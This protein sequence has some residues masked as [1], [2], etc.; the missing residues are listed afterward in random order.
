MGVSPLRQSITQ[1][2]IGSPRDE[3]GG[4]PDRPTDGEEGPDRSGGGDEDEDEHDECSDEEQ[5][6][7][8]VSLF[9]APKE[10]TT[11]ITDCAELGGAY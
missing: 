4:Y 10:V 2:L 1:H 11:E 9:D 6:T 3:S 5:T 8:R 7:H